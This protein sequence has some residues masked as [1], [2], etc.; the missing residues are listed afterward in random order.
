MKFFLPENSINEVKLKLRRTC[1][2]HSKN[3]G[4]YKYKKVINDLSKNNNTV[5]MRKEKGKGVVIMDKTKQFGK[6]IETKIQRVL[7]KIKNISSQEYSRLSPTGYSSGKVFRT[8]KIYKLS[9]TN[10]ILKLP[11]SPI[12][13]NINTPTHQLAKI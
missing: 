12:V 9:P 2:N 5:V 7:R 13:S 6:D 3:R 4:P 11:I 10:N 1:E 8:A